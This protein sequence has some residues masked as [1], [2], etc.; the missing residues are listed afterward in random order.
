MRW[1]PSLATLPVAAVVTRPPR[2]RSPVLYS[3]GLVRAQQAVETGGR[4]RMGAFR[5]AALATEFGFAVVGSLLGGVVGGLYLDSR[6]GTAPALFL[7][8]VAGG[9]VFSV[10]LIYVIYRVQV[11]PGRRSTAV[12]SDDKRDSGRLTHGD[13]R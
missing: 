1:R 13:T 12:P 7:A 4:K 8:G 6:F 11:Q 9:L 10:Y 5:A 3:G 2:T